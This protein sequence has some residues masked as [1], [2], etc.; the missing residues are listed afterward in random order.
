MEEALARI[1]EFIER[2]MAHDG[3]PGL[4]LAVT[5]TTRTLAVRTYGYADLAAKTPVQ[6]TH[7]FQTGSTGKSFAA[8][9]VMQEVEAGRLRLN[10]PVTEYL[11]WFKVSSRFG[12]ITLHHLLSHSAGISTGN[13]HSPGAGFQSHASVG[14]WLISAN[15]APREASS[16]RLARAISSG[17][18]G[19]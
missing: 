4:A 17:A 19:T 11:P 14:R 16:Q 7:L 13:D 2:E 15:T 1:D 12:P 18:M 5:D 6:P 9:M 3:P 10:A 8:F